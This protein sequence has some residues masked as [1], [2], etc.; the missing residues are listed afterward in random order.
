MMKNSQKHEIFVVA[1]I[2]M[3]I[4][5]SPTH[6][7]VVNVGNKKTLALLKYVCALRRIC[8]ISERHFH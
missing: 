2:V 8:I 6:A 7:G 1:G 4:F 3:T 5:H